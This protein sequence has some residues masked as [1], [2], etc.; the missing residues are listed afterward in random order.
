MGKTKTTDRH[1][2][3]ERLER[4]GTL[5]DCAYAVALILVV[6]WLPLPS[7]SQNADGQVYFLQLFREFAGNMLSIVV[8]V[9]F[10]IIYW[11]R[12]TDL[13]ARVDRTDGPHVIL[14]ILSGFSMLVLLYVVRAGSEVEGAESATLD[15]RCGATG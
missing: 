1:V 9:V 12:N 14:S 11:L 10:I 13:T 6:Q 5:T 2:A 4:L 3:R 7:E 15:R 8:A